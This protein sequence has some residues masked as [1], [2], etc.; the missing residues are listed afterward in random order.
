MEGW[1]SAELALIS[2]KSKLADAGRNGLTRLTEDGGIELDNSAVE[3]F[4]RLITLWKNTP[5]AGSDGGAEHWAIIA[6]VLEICK[7]NDVDPLA[8][9]SDTHLHRQRPG[10]DIDELPRW[11]P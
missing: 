2:Q 1:L 7:L 3:R 4:I 8:Y 9:L 6:S 11:G 10:S 5:F